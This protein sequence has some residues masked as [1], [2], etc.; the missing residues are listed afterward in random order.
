MKERKVFGE[1]V[2]NGPP[3]TDRKLKVL[4]KEPHDIN[5]FRNSDLVNRV[6]L[7]NDEIEKQV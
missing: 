5:S 7:R 2:L 6:G 1:F 3:K 4:R